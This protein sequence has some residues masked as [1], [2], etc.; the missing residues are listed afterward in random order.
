MVIMELRCSE[1]YARFVS[2]AIIERYLKLFMNKV[3]QRPDSTDLD[4][5]DYEVRRCRH[6]FRLFASPFFRKR[7]S[8]ICFLCSSAITVNAWRTTPRGFHR[9][10]RIFRTSAEFSGEVFLFNE[11]AKSQRR[12]ISFST[13]CAL[14]HLKNCTNET[15]I[16]SL[17]SETMKLRLQADISDVFARHSSLSVDTARIQLKPA[18]EFQKFV[19]QIADSMGLLT[20][21]NKLFSLFGISYIKICFF[22]ANSA[23]DRVRTVDFLSILDRYFLFDRFRWPKRRDG[24]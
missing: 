15:T 24:F 20:E 13:I 19:Q 6:P 23:A 17:L 12:L 14:L 8:T 21:Y 2:Q 22:E 3:Q 7:C 11:E 4:I 5:T 18:A 16:K 9:R 1:D 10:N